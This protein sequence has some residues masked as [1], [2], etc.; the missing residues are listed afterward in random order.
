MQAKV[1]VHAIKAPAATAL[2]A[3]PGSSVDA[4]VVL[5]CLPAGGERSLQEFT[6]GAHRV[7]RPGGT[8]VFVQR[9][10]GEGLAAV[11]QPLVGG[12]AQLGEL[13]GGRAHL[14]RVFA[15]FFGGSL[16]PP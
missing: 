7:L 11:V 16:W 1:P 2:A 5:G 3:Q 14:L 10:R 4:V 12:A 15:A 6:R 13:G 9:V 8:L